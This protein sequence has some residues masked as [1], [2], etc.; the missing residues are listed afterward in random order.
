MIDLLDEVLEIIDEDEL[1]AVD[2][3]TLVPPLPENE[4]VCTAI[5]SAWRCHPKE[6]GVLDLNQILG[7][8]EYLALHNFWLG[9]EIKKYMK[10][11]ER[12]D[13]SEST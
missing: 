3:G 8:A 12:Q 9:Y 4:D 6:V 2:Y 1:P 10:R 5:G 7:E 11:R 13:G